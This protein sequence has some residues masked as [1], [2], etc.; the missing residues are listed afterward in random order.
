MKNLIVEIQP[1]DFKQNIY[2]FDNGILTSTINTTMKDLPQKILTTAA[3]EE[4]TNISIR[5]AVDFTQKI[6]E[7][8]RVEEVTKYG[9]HILEIDLV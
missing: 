6:K 7:E 8:V 5:G 1:F 9:K 2:V 4:I 3:A